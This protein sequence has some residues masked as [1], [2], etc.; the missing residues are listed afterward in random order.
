MQHHPERAITILNIVVTGVCFDILVD[1]ICA[2]RRELSCDIYQNRAIKVRR[3]SDLFLR[4]SGEFRDQARIDRAEQFAIE[5]LSA[6]TLD[7][8][9]T[10]LE[11][12]GG[13]LFEG[14]DCL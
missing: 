11:R 6:D 10:N 8:L 1:E 14:K 9:L 4:L 12:Q 2:L 13:L 7:Q 3:V 5:L